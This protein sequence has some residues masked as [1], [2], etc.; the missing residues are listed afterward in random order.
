MEFFRHQK[1]TWELD[2]IEDLDTLS[3]VEQHN[4][5][6]KQY[7]ALHHQLV[8]S[9]LATRMAHE[10]SGEYQIGCMIAGIT[11]YPYSC[12]LKISLLV[13]KERRNIFYIV[14]IFK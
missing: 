6:V 11:Q 14:L 1:R 3:T 5:I 4:D 9:A 2:V 12:R 8:A 7:Q 10:I 13:Q